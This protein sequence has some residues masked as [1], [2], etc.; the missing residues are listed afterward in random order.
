MPQ[1]QPADTGATSYLHQSEKKKEVGFWKK[2]QPADS[3]ATSYLHH[4]ASNTPLISAPEEL[5]YECLE[6]REYA[7]G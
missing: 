5:A 4:L 1:K 7:G 3:V 6:E 2:K